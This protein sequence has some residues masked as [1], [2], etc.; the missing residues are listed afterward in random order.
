[1]FMRLLV[2]CDQC[3]LRYDATG[4]RA[5]TFAT[6]AWNPGTHTLT[7]D[8]RDDR[9]NTVAPGVYFL[10]IEAGTIRET[11]RWVVLR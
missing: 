8:G 3:Q 9:G 2:Q 10:R 1:M 7:W 11:V 4:R 5:R 6:G